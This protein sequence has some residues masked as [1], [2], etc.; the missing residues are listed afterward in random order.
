LKSN[1][2]VWSAVLSYTLGQ[3]SFQRGN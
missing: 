3:W 1:R 2:L